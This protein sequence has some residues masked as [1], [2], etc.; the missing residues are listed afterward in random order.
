MVAPPV[1]RRPGHFSAKQLRRLAGRFGRDR[2]GTVLVEFAFVAPLL[3]L[4]LLGCFDVSRLALLHQKMQRT[5]STVADLVGGEASLT[6]A[7]LFGLMD[8]AEHVMQP[9]ALGGDGVVIVSS[10][11]V[12][13]SGGGVTA[14]MNWQR[15]GIDSPRPSAGRLA[16]ASVYGS[17]GGTVT[18]PAGI[19]PAAGRS[20][21]VIAAEVWYDYQPLLMPMLESDAPLHH[22]AIYRPRFADLAILN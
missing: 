3:V 4:L 19:T 12:T 22:A 1:V 10:I 14:T 2:R 17:P 16:L 8:A 6:D 7:A 13:G 15:S 20:I 11:T 18:P 9:F 5:A 21:T